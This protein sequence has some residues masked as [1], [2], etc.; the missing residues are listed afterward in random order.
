MRDHDANLAAVILADEQARANQLAL[1]FP[2]LDDRADDVRVTYGELRRRIAQFQTGIANA[3][4]RPG[5]RVALLL[6]AGADFF[7]LALALLASGQVIVVLDGRMDARRVIRALSVAG[8]RAVVSV[9]A[10]LKR[11]PLVPPLWRAR[12]IAVDGRGFG[13]TSLEVLIGRGESEVAVLPRDGADPAMLSFTSGSTGRPKGAERTHGILSAQHLALKDHAPDR[14]GEIDMPCFPAIVLHNLACGLTTVLPPIDLRHPGQADARRVAAAI[15][16]F[17]VTSLSGAPAYMARLCDHLLAQRSPATTIRRVFIGGAPVGRRLCERV[18]AAF[19][20]AES[21]V[22]YGST[23]AEP[24]T[25]VALHEVVAADGDGYLVGRAAPVAD[26]ALVDLPDEP[27]RL[28]ARGIDPHRVPDGASGEVVVRGPHVV[29]RYLGDDDATRRSKL[30]M[31]DGSVWHRTYDLARRDGAGR[32]WLTG[33]TSDV[34]LHRGRRVEPYPIEAAAGELPGVV[35]AALVSHA[36]AEHGELLLQCAPAIA[37]DVTAAARELLA[38][39][40]L[41]GVAIETVHELPMDARHNSKIDRPELR[42]AR[43]NRK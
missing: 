6:P 29:R 4:L 34:V 23:E 13:V 8:A 18:L 20:A 1:V 26:I 9:R 25:S 30:P 16:R 32:L 39:R 27:P 42:A 19:P 41:D 3:G 2:A 33:R 15:A 24:M 31:P 10:V 12:R 43:Q 37:A 22:V 5:D 40:D 38:A 21:E 11:W 7:A 35:A 14:D 28:D 17:G 36:R